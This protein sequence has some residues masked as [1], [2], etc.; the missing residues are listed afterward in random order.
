MLFG[1]SKTSNTSPEATRVGMGRVGSISALGNKSPIPAP[2]IKENSQTIKQRS[3]TSPESTKFF[4]FFS[5]QRK[6]ES[7]SPLFCWS[8]VIPRGAIT[9]F[10][11]FSFWRIQVLQRAGAFRMYQLHS[12]P[13][14]AAKWLFTVSNLIA[15][16]PPPAFF[17]ENPL[18]RISCARYYGYTTS[19]YNFASQML[20]TPRDFFLLFF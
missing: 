14:L 20:L 17:Q 12:N 8:V 13:C 7:L 5:Y 1:G 4:F 10:S 3:K 2:K 19:Y 15:C 18:F 9:S 11:H 16:F 6:E